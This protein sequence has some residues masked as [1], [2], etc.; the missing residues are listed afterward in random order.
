MPCLATMIG[1]QEAQDK[2][3]H[4]VPVVVEVAAAEFYAKRTLSCL[5]ALLPLQEE[6]AR[7]QVEKKTSLS[8]RKTL[9]L[10][11]TGSEGIASSTELLLLKELPPT[12]PLRAKGP[13]PPS[14]ELIAQYSE[15]YVLHHHNFEFIH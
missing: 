15:C 3:E 4:D 2:D 8:S 5:D 14:T 12:L 10:F 1:S 7:A 6:P 13:F 9:L 11:R